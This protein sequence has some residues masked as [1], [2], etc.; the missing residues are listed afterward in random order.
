VLEPRPYR[1]RE[2]L[3]RMRRLLVEGRSLGQ[4][5]YYVHVGDLN[6]WLFYSLRGLDWS[7]I[8]HLWE[9]DQDRSL[10]GWSLFS[11]AYRS[12]DVFVH[13]TDCSPGMREAMVG[14]AVAHAEAAVRRAG[15]PYLQTMWVAKH[16][17]ELV[18]ILEGTGFERSGD[19]LY[20]LERPL[21]ALPPFEMLSGYQVRSVA[22]EWEAKERARAAH[23]AFASSR[24]FD[25]YLQNYVE[26]MR[27]P[28]YEGDLDV[29]AISPGGEVASFCIAWLDRTNRIGLLEPVG[30]RPA[31]Q[32]LGLGKATVLE[33]LRR[34]RAHGM[35]T[36]MVCVED[37]NRAA[38]GLYTS[39]GFSPANELHTYARMLA[40]Q[41]NGL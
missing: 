13:P 37:G 15:G 19:F 16:D 2:D 5:P 28:V 39:L 18:S 30:T 36:A 29:V 34:L 17:L 20:Q 31:Y 33:A 6:W 32:R 11:P 40:E 25:T 26:F 27:S 35:E 10:L 9:R 8:L 14:W 12:F 4:A 22:G 1:D 7:Q 38:Q 24:P 41:R 23:E 21:G 3:D